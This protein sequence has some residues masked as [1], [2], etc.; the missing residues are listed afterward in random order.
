MKNN[1]LK[2]VSV[3]LLISSFQVSAKTVLADRYA[4]VSSSLGEMKVFTMYLSKNLKKVNFWNNERKNEILTLSGDVAVLECKFPGECDW[5]Q[6]YP[7][8]SFIIQ[9]CEAANCN[10]GFFF[11]TLHPYERK[12][13]TECHLDEEQIPCPGT[14]GGN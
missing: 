14:T 9:N 2:F 5:F 6:T 10:G 12:I 1:F 13:L 11:Q 7:S 4:C 3:C 8:E